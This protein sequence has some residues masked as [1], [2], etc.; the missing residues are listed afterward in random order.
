MTDKKMPSFSEFLAKARRKA[1]KKGKINRKEAC[2]L[3]NC[4]YTQAIVRVKCAQ[5]EAHEEIEQGAIEILK[6][7]EEERGI[8]RVE[9]GEA[10]ALACIY[11]TSILENGYGQHY[12][13]WDLEKVADCVASTIRSYVRKIQKVIPLKKGEKA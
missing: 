5:L 1:Q 3:L 13:Y 12:T 11:I 4:K 7:Y 8:G 9:M 10:L 6:T 2:V